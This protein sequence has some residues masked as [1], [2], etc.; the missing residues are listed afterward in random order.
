MAGPGITITSFG[1]ARGFPPGFGGFG[2]GSG[3]GGDV[4]A[5]STMGGNG[6]GIVHI[7]EM[8]DP[9]AMAKQRPPVVQTISVSLETLYRGGFVNCCIESQATDSMGPVEPQRKKNFEVEIIPGY[10]NGTQ[11]K[12]DR[13]FPDDE[14]Y[15]GEPKVDVTFVVQEEK[16][17]IFKRNGQHLAADI[18]LSKEQIGAETFEIPL[19]FL[20]GETERIQGSR[21]TCGHGTKRV[22]KGRGMPVRRGGQGTSEF[23]DLTLRFVWPISLR[24]PQQCC[25]VS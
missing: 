12:F 20:S 14:L 1:D 10:R 15:P 7:I 3:G 18:K 19:K 17:S 9:A 22:L 16:H 24:G 21:G 4:L 23:G 11:I 13:C 25:T 5:F 8:P 6:T 2:P